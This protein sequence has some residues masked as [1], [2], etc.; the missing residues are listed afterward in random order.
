MENVAEQQHLPWPLRV[1]AVAVLATFLV[2]CNI[3]MVPFMNSAAPDS[4][5]AMLAYLC[6]GGFWSQT[7]LLAMW[8]TLFRGNLLLRTLVTIAAAGVLTASFLTGAYVTQ[9]MLRSLVIIVLPCLPLV[10]VVGELPLWGLHIWAGWRIEVSDQEKKGPPFTIQHAFL[11]TGVFAVA[12]ALARVAANEI[13]WVG[14]AMASG[15][16]F[17]VS[18]VVLA[19]LIGFALRVRRTWL[20]ILGVVLYTCVGIVATATFL[21]GVFMPPDFAA[22]VLVPTGFFLVISGSLIGARL[23]GY[24]LRMD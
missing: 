17:G 6:L 18:L 21:M 14:I 8:H 9:G 2:L 24:R 15:V 20:A 3:A 19:P 13:G 12:L 22:A 11:L 1:I 7:P 5:H 4:L 10:M 16:L 23:L